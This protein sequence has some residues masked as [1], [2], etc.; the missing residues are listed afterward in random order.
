MR[1]LT[2]IAP[3]EAAHKHRTSIRNMRDFLQFLKELPYADTCILTVGDGVSISRIDREAY[4]EFI[5]S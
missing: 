3:E 1:G 2:A 4:Q 5:R